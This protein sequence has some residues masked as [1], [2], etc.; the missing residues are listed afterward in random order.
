[1]D[2]LKTS[3]LANISYEIRTPMNAIIGMAEI[4]ESESLNERQ[5][6]FV[7]DIRISAQ[8]LLGIIDDILDLSK[9]ESGKFELNP[10][11]YNFM[12][13][14]DNITSMFTYIAGNKGIR[15]MFEP[16]S[17]IPHLLYGDD[18]RLKQV[19]VN[20]CSNAIKYTEQGFVK[21]SAISAGQK[22][23]IKVEDTGLGIRKETIP[24]LF[25]AYEQ[26]EKDKNK[27]IIGSGL[28]LS[29]SKSLIEMM[30]GQITVESEYGKGSVFTVT[31]PIV[32]AGK[33]SGKPSQGKSCEP[34]LSISAPNAKV[35]VVDDNEFNIRVASG[36]LRIMD[37]NA[38]GA[39]TGTKAI[40]LIKANEYDI[41]FMDYMM[42]DMDGAEVARRIKGLGARFV[43]LPI[44]ALSANVADGAKEMFLEQGFNGYVSKPIDSDELAKA[45]KQWLPPEKVASVNRSLPPVS[46]KVN[47][48]L[49]RFFNKRLLS[50]CE[51]MSALIRE[52]DVKGF[53]IQIHAM[54]SS[55]AIIKEMVLSEMAGDL[56]KSAKKGNIAHCSEYYATFENR[57]HEL[58]QRLNVTF[59]DVKD[60]SEAAEV[61]SG[62]AGGAAERAKATV[63]GSGGNSALTRG[64]DEV[65]SAAEDFDSDE[66]A[67]LVEALMRQVS[68]SEVNL[69]LNEALE[70][71]SDFDCDT[72]AQK[73]AKIKGISYKRS[74]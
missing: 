32:R 46:Q 52:G 21:L 66:G 50:D 9:I 14:A 65:I 34:K 71:F 25:N 22:L 68:D 74:V 67:R 38:D 39:S 23:I 13:L 49:V 26:T 60:D 62:T 15:F 72:A 53:A 36:L 63:K 1:M 18:M 69:L 57:L 4:L 55:L 48:D 20:L 73:L 61:E 37:I 44:I 54:R 8:S 29:V 40:S 12:Q 6:S 56:E 35:L 10:V 64:I 2:N 11:A 30:G 59:P 28:G 31:V 7:K 27:E 42:P 43:R 51:K 33:V 70:A 17:N 47:P 3:F 41:V 16:S 19:L 58:H 5:L 24:L 45:L